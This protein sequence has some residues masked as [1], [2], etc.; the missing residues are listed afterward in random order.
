MSW[1]ALVIGAVGLTT[2][3]IARSKAK[4]AQKKQEA[5]AN[6]QKPDQGI[7]DYYNKALSRYNT[8]PY[9]SQFYQNQK[10]NADRNLATGINALQSRRS[11]VGGLSSLISGNND[12]NRS[13]GI[14]AEQLQNQQF[15]QLGQAAGINAQ[16]QKYPMEMKYNLYGAQAAGYNQAE[17]AGMQTAYNGIGGFAAGAMNKWGNKKTA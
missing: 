16:E 2:A 17:N 1:G 11:A 14:N 4:K 10:Q 7:T 6:A 12:A 15:G 13:A 8:N 9:Q 5:L 3:A